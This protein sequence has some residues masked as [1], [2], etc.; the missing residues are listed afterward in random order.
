MLLFVGAWGLLS[1]GYLL[2]VGQL[3]ADE[4]GLALACGLAAA[5]WSVAI[6]R[7]AVL[8]FR[9]EPAAAWVIITAVAK[10]PRTIAAVATALLHARNG[11]VVWELFIRGR[12]FD[13]A[14]AAR[15]AIAMLAVSL[16]PDKF[17]LRLPAA[18]DQIE[19]HTLAP[20]PAETD[21]RWPT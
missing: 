7:V 13:L 8:G 9:F 3:S 1:L 14:D 17:A 18:R 12:D 5:G 10:L 21:P 15:R 6:R 19:L 11:T 4:I 20:V 16:T 2:L